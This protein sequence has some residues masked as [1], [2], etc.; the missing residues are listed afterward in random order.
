[1]LEHSKIWYWEYD[2]YHWTICSFEKKQ[3]KRSW[4][5]HLSKESIRKIAYRQTMWRVYRRTRQDEYC[6][7]YKEALKPNDKWKKKNETRRF[8][9]SHGLRSCNLR[10]MYDERLNMTQHVNAVCR[11]GCYHI[12]DIGRIRRNM[13]VFIPQIYIVYE[14]Y[15]ADLFT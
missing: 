13:A 3:G 15:E 12:R 6:T 10:V 8:G 14:K 11:T 9:S 7:N 4:K 5:K 1:M 2:Q